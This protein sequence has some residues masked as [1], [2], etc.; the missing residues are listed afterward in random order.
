MAADWKEQEEEVARIKQ[1]RDKR[2]KTEAASLAEEAAVA[3]VA[4]VAA[5]VAT[6]VVLPRDARINGEVPRRRLM[7][8]LLGP[9]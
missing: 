4:A 2:L 8:S 3:E 1:A 9:H 6:A 5:T 7:A